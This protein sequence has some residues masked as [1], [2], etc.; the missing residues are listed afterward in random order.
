[1]RAH[2]YLFKNHNRVKMQYLQFHEGII[3]ITV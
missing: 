1:M 3:I 2:L